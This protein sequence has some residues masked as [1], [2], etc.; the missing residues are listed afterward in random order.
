MLVLINA[1]WAAG[2]ERFERVMIDHHRSGKIRLQQKLFK[3]LK[4]KRWEN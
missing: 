4:T 2:K 1:N 3:L